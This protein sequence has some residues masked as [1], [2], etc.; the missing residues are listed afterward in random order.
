M[1]SKRSE[2]GRKSEARLRQMDP[3][4]QAN[5]VECDEA[6]GICHQS[7]GYDRDDEACAA[8]SHSHD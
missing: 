2:K 6:S 4:F 1:I 5:Y 7:T 8:V 3:T